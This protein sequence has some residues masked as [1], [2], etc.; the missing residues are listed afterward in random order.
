MSP[1]SRNAYSFKRIESPSSKLDALTRFSVPLLL[2]P[3]F[4]VRMMP[5]TWVFEVIASGG[6][7]MILKYQLY[8]PT[9][10][11]LA[12]R[13]A[14]ELQLPVDAPRALADGT[15]QRFLRWHGRQR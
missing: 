6:Y 12:R 14:E 9:H 1:S 8:P 11:D 10:R 7:G 3:L 13:V 2:R 4:V 5:Q 15:M